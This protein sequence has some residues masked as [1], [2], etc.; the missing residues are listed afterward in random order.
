MVAELHNIWD[1]GFLAMTDE[2]YAAKQR[3]RLYLAEGLAA[4]KSLKTALSTFHTLK[5]LLWCVQQL[6]SLQP[7]ASFEAVD[8]NPH[9]SRD[10]VGSDP[11]L[12][13]MAPKVKKSSDKCASALRRCQIAHSLY[14]LSSEFE[15]PLFLV[16]FL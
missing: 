10:V 4:T 12:P 16:F 6:P 1:K 8:G 13:P 9:S 3:R 15:S 7:A 14:L 2:E 5:L 11:P